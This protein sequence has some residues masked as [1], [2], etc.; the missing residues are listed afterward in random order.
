MCI[1]ECDVP[2]PGIPVSKKFG[3]V[4]KSRNR[5]RKSLVPWK[6]IGTSIGKSLYRKKYRNRY[7]KIWYQNYFFSQNLGNLKIYNG[8]QYR[9]GTG[10]GNFNFFGAGIGKNWDRKKYRNRYRKNLVP[11]KV[12]ESVSKKFGT[13]KNVW[14]SVSKIFVSEKSLGI[15]LGKIWYRK[16]LGT[17]IEIFLYW[18]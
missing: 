12:S 14:E 3:T 10:T 13:K 11:K 7:R 17:G 9:I 5:Y 18:N 1:S 6:G 15:G 8:Y 2:V 4:K 16:S